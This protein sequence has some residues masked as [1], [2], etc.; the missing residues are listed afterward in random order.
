MRVVRYDPIYKEDIERLC[1]AFSEES[2][3]EYNVGTREDT[4]GVV[5]KSVEQGCFLLITDE[6]KA[7]GVIAGL[8]VKGIAT[9]DPALQEIIWYVDKEYRSN[10]KMLLD[11]FEEYGKM[12]GATMI[13]MCLMCNSMEERLDKVYTRLGYKRFEVQYM[14]ELPN[15]RINA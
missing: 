15:A 4:V 13:V 6:G 1:K 2:L 11:Q 12:Q 7:V 9:G 14:K 3:N 5:L 8:M 10:G